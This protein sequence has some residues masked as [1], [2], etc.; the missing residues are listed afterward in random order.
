MHV[1]WFSISNEKKI[2][3]RVSGKASIRQIPETRAGLI[4]AFPA[5]IHP[6]N[7][8]YSSD[9]IYFVK[10][11]AILWIRKHTRCMC[12]SRRRRQRYLN[13]VFRSAEISLTRIPRRISR[14]DM[15][16]ANL[17]MRLCISSAPQSVAQFA[18]KRREMHAFAAC[19]KLRLIR[20]INTTERIDSRLCTCTRI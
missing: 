6:L 7:F 10:S 20:V 2:F 11:L 16:V 1:Q 3:E 15:E 5:L 17:R 13:A 14:A 12:I 19:L 8:W 4:T 9:I 18:C